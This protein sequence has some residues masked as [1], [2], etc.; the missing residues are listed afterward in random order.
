MLRVQQTLLPTPQQ[1]RRRRT[2]GNPLYLYFSTFLLNKNDE[3]LRTF[4]NSLSIV[5]RSHF[6]SPDRPSVGSSPCSPATPSDVGVDFIL[7]S[8]EK[9]GEKRLEKSRH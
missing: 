5:V 2:L 1:S 6:S 7:P 3:N 8:N 9:E 4:P